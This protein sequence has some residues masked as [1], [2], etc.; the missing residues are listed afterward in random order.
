MLR[1]SHAT[2]APLTQRRVGGAATSRRPCADRTQSHLAPQGQQRH[3]LVEVTLG[4]WTCSLRSS[5]M[6]LAP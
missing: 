6:L 3:C 4:R 1:R 5:P 2:H